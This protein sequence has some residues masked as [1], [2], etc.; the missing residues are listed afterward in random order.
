MRIFISYCDSE[1][2]QLAI[3]IRD[4]LKASPEAAKHALTVTLDREHIHGGDGITDEISRLLN[5]TSVFVAIITENYAERPYV[6]HELAIAKERYLEK[7]TKIIPVLPADST[8]NGHEAVAKIF[9]NDFAYISVSTSDWEQK[10]SEAIFSSKNASS[11]KLTFSPELV[12]CVGHEQQEP[13]WVAHIRDFYTDKTKTQCAYIPVAFSI[14]RL[15]GL[16]DR[17]DATNFA[18][19]LVKY[20]DDGGDNTFGQSKNM[21]CIIAHK[22]AASVVVDAMKMHKIIKAD[23]LILCG[24]T[25]SETTD[26]SEQINRGQV[27][28]I[29]NYQCDYTVLD[30]FWNLIGKHAACYRGL[31]EVDQFVQNIRFN[32]PYSHTRSRTHSVTICADILTKPPKPFYIRHSIDVSDTDLTRIRAGVR[33]MDEDAYGSLSGYEDTKIP[34]EV[35]IKWLGANPDLYTYLVNQESGEC[36]GYINAMP[37][38]RTVFNAIRRGVISDD[39]IRPEN[40]APYSGGIYLYIMSIN[41]ARWAGIGHSGSPLFWRA[42]VAGLCAKLRYYALKNGTRVEELAAVAWTPQGERF[43]DLLG[44]RKVAKDSWGHHV[45]TMNLRENRLRDGKSKEMRRIL[46][47]FCGLQGLLEVYRSLDTRSQ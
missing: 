31:I 30:S 39:R 6:K 41:T 3:N 8:M 32:G 47:F 12:I 37:L 38:D 23:R 44:M 25:L 20:F 10:L 24:A 21:P 40:I 33:R 43:C 35:P 5:D 46:R 11:H 1:A 9:S 4:R 42:I 22:H 19:R 18:D 34:Y 29:I 36:V 2:A 28:A 7:N 16:T 17:N 13:K 45:Y 27:N 14:R 15:I 26:F